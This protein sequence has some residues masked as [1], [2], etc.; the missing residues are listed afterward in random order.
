M[1]SML[2]ILI[3]LAKW[4]KIPNDTASRGIERRFRLAKGYCAQSDS[5]PLGGLLKDFSLSLEVR[6]RGSDVNLAKPWSKWETLAD[7][8]Y[9]VE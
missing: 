5:L 6:M 4:L 1:R 9:V 8:G 3:R 7:A 2:K